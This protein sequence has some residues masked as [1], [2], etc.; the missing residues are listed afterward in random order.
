MSCA[1]RRTKQDVTGIIYE[2]W[3][4]RI[5]GKTHAKLMK[6]SGLCLEEYL[7]QEVPEGYT[8]IADP[9]ADPQTDLVQ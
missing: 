7:Q 4:Y 2:S 8:G 3:H 5:V 9:Y 6:E 1:T